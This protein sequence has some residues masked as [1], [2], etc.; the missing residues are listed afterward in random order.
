MARRRRRRISF[1]TILMLVLTIGA[2]GLAG[3]T[4][5][6]IAGDDL[7]LQTGRFFERMAE[8]FR[9]SE[10]ARPAP[11][12]AAPEASAAQASGV[13]QETAVPE[14]TPQPSA[15]PTA[16]PQQRTVT[17][18]AVGS[19]YAPKNIRQSGYDE[20]SGT[21]DFSALFGRV[22]PYVSQADLT[23]GTIETYFAGEEAGYSNYNAPDALLDAI[24]DSGFD[25]LSLASEYALEKGEDGLRQ[26]IMQLENR[27]MIAAGAYVD[28][29]QVGSAQMIKINGVQI[30][31]LAYTYGFSDNT[32]E[33]TRASQREGV[34][35]IRQSDMVRDIGNAR[36]AGADVVI[37]LPHWGTKNKEEVASHTRSLARALAEAGADLILGAHPNVVQPVEKMTV[38]RSDGAQHDAYVAYSLGSFLT[39]SREAQ[40]TAGMV[41][42]VRFTYDPQTRTI[43]FDE[44]GYMPTY[45]QRIRQGEQYDY[46]ILAC[47]DESYIYALDTSTQKAIQSARE[48]VVETVGEDARDLSR[49]ET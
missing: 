48:A 12:G 42:Q 6:Y 8:T 16:A 31:V 1:G 29:E 19:I 40:N 18:S 9:H 20:E 39:D 35:V 4:I 32:M 7:R 34:S 44:V 14:A 13:P 23:L 5:G 28:P 41:L 30:A 2:L 47:A 43:R 17:L 46:R 11:V 33:R 26:T 45:I 22:K 49:P 38:T 36:K 21:Y 37:V 3:A 24:R 27:G 15:A 10:I 25:L